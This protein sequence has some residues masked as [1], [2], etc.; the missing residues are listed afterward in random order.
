MTIRSWIWRSMAAGLSGSAVH[1]LFMYFKSHFGLLPAFQP[2]QSFQAALSYWVGTNVP[3]IVPW[4]LSFLN[5]MTIL[6]FLFARANRLLPGSTGAAKGMTFGLIGWVLM[7][8]IFFPAI[9][10]GPFA[11][12]VGSGLRP[13]LL[14][15]VMLQTYSIVLGTVYAALDASHR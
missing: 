7:G 9:G 13:A 8:L 3:A 2:Y 5:G 4:A 6:G 15:L 1:F 11:I 10:L 12:R 14:S